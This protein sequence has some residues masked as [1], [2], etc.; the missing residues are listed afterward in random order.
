MT[1]H[2]NVLL[3]KKHIL[4]CLGE[5]LLKLDDIYKTELV[6]IKENF[7]GNVLTCSD[8]IADFAKSTDLQ[9]IMIYM[10]IYLK[11]YYVMHIHS[12]LCYSRT[13]L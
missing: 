3:T 4:I 12:L 8:K 5:E 9:N 1:E 13:V 2:E 7:L 11:S 10:I 6:Y